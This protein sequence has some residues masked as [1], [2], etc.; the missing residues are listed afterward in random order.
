MMLG[1]S[2]STV[3]SSSSCRENATSC[4]VAGLRTVKSIKGIAGGGGG[5]G[6]F[7]VPGTDISGKGGWVWAAAGKDGSRPNSAAQKTASVTRRITVP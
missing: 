1:A 3:S 6:M 4:P 5:A 7:M 2:E